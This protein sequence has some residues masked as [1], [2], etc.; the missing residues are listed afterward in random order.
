MGF[1][2]A[3]ASGW[4]EASTIQKVNLVVDILCRVGAGFAGNRV[5]NM[6][7]KDA[8]KV[9]TICVKTFTT[10]MGLYLGGKAGDAL[11]LPETK[12]PEEEKKEEQANG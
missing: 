5:G 8:G 3:L 7:T 6:L 1:F 9:E 4:K 2:K 11:I 10:G 12:K